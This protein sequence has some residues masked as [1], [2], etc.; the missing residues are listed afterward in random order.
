[1]QGNH[2]GSRETS[3][4]QGD[5]GAKDQSI[6][7]S[8]ENALRQENLPALHRH[9]SLG[10]CDDWK[11][12]NIIEECVIVADVQSPARECSNDTRKIY[13]NPIHD[14]AEGV[15]PKGMVY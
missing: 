10:D 2:T 3:R 15:A 11:E 14:T 5:C 13:T 7:Q 1:M 12:R 8:L 6:S 9:E 4:Q